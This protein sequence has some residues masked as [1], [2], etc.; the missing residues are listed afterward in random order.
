METG[1]NRIMAGVQQRAECKK[2]G[3]VREQ[4]T[5]RAREGV[6]VKC[7][8]WSSRI[9]PG[10]KGSTFKVNLKKNERNVR[11]MSYSEFGILNI[12]SLTVAGLLMLIFMDF[13]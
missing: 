2:M 4:A 6:A 3:R 1:C 7:P 5:E 12:Y 10:T 9:K 8:V 13:R 11:S